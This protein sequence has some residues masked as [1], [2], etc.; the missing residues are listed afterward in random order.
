MRW[1]AIREETSETEVMKV[2]KPANV[3]LLTTTGGVLYQITLS[4]AVD[5]FV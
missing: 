3:D 2:P 1:E 5:V 4:R